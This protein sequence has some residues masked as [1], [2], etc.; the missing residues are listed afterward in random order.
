MS[1]RSIIA[2]VAVQ[3]VSG[4]NVEG[5]GRVAL[6]EP[7]QVAIVGNDPGTESTIRLKLAQG[8]TID[9]IF[10]G[11]ATAGETPVGFYSGDNHGFENLLA[12]AALPL[13]TLVA[14]GRRHYLLQL[15]Q[16]ISPRYLSLYFGPSSAPFQI[17]LFAAGL[18]FRPKWGGEFGGGVGL[19]DTGAV[20][21]RRDGG[22]GIDEGVT[23]AQLQWTFGDLSDVERAQLFALLRERGTSRPAIVIE[24]EDT[25]PMLTEEVHYG[26][27]TRIEA[28][29]R[30]AP[31]MNRWALR[32]ED[33][34]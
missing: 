11:F 33:W 9:T 17:G 3:D 22:F 10:V 34:E 1:V 25:G 27:F 16:P 13:A 8:A 14:R 12:A 28:Y 7:K 6:P 26:L 15:A 29:E 20:S 2:P 4:F 5:A 30:F 32:F 21:R 31:G 23:A 19:T 24:G 18:A